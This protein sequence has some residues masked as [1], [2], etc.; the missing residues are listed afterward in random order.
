MAGPLP[1]NNDSVRKEFVCDSPCVPN[2]QYRWKLGTKF[3]TALTGF[4]AG[5]LVATMM[6]YPWLKFLGD[7]CPDQQNHVTTGNVETYEEP[8]VEPAPAEGA[9]VVPPTE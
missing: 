1:N 3:A 8:P 7:L 9:I 5:A 6:L 4:V 2:T